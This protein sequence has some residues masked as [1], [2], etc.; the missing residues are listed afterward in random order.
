ME[1][2]MFIVGAIIFL[3][4]MFFTI[5]NIFYNNQK[6]SEENGVIQ[7]NDKMDY[8]GMGDFSRFIDDV[9]KKT[10]KNKVIK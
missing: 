8:D 2:G 9:P 1:I 7:I 3:V 4:Y 6:Q 10:R 5:W